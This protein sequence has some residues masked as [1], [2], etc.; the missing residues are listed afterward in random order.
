MSRPLRCNLRFS[1]NFKSNFRS[2]GF[3][4]THTPVKYGTQQQIMLTFTPNN[5]K[6]EPPIVGI[7]WKENGQIQK[8]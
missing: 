3:E 8:K 4:V 6:I 5:D 1:G 2:K 7:A